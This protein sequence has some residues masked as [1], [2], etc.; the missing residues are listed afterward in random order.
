MVSLVLTLIV[1]LA[2]IAFLIWN[3]IQLTSILNDIF[4]D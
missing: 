3:V 2:A 1:F 4:G